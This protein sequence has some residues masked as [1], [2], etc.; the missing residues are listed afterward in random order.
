MRSRVI[1]IVNTEVAAWA[2]VAAATEIFFSLVESHVSEI[3]Y[4]GVLNTRSSCRLE[5][6]VPKK[7]NG[8]LASIHRWS[9][10]EVSSDKHFNI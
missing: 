7:I 9:T 8:K 4:K 5:F 1:I 10:I 2:V 3:N 6:D